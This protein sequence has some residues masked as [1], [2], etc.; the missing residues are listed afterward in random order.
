VDLGYMKKLSGAGE[1]QFLTV[2]GGPGYWLPTTHQLFYTDRS[3]T[4]QQEQ[5]RLA[6]STLIW[7]QGDVTYRLEGQLTRDQA[8]RIAESMR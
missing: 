5:A 8:I 6:G 1:V 3:G 4:P 7:Q 2:A